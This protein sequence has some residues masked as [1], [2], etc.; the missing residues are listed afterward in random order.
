MAAEPHG[1]MPPKQSDLGEFVDGKTVNVKGFFATEKDRELSIIN[2]LRRDIPLPDE[3][4]SED[5]RVW[6]KYHRQLMADAFQ[7]HC[8]TTASSGGP[9]RRCGTGKSSLGTGTTNSRQVPPL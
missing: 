4:P 1:D 3:K 5:T 2:D 8:D 6:K 7:Q 9:R